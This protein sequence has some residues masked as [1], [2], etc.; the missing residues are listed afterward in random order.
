MPRYQK[1]SKIQVFRDRP[2]YQ[3]SEGS[4][5]DD[6]NVKLGTLWANVRGK[7]FSETYALNSVWVEPVFTMTV[8]RPTYDI[9]PGD[10]VIHRGR[11]F[12]VKTVND[13]TGQLGHDM[14]LVV[15]ADDQFE[16]EL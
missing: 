7:D 2:A 5:H 8:S 12:E 16:P 4:F 1:N 15:Q 3:D 9:L 14:V 6:G 13:L 11:C 10:H